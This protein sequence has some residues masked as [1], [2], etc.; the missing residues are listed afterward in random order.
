MSSIRVLQFPSQGQWEHRGVEKIILHHSATSST[1]NGTIAGSEAILRSIYRTHI[2][3]DWGNGAKAPNIAYHYAMDIWGRIWR[4]NPERCITWHA[5][6]VNPWALG[7]VVLGNFENRS[8]S[9]PERKALADGWDFLQD[10]FHTRY[11]I[12]KSDWQPHSAVASTSCCGRYLRQALD[13]W[14]YAS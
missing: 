2:Q 1:G 8:L 5:G 11:K 9:F 10:R 6:Y 12:K 7:I 13:Q 3:R 14:K 4:L